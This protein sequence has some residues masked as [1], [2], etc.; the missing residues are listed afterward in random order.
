MH[1]EKGKLNNWA[2]ANLYNEKLRLQSFDFLL[3]DSIFNTTFKIK[4]QIMCI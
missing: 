2:L 3:F 4:W 1:E